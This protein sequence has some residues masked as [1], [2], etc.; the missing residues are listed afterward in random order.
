MNYDD[1]LAKAVEQ[2]DVH[3]KQW[4]WDMKNAQKLRMLGIN[5]IHEAALRFGELSH[6]PHSTEVKVLCPNP[7]HDDT[8]P[9]CSLWTDNNTFK[10]WSCGYSGGLDWYVKLMEDKQ[11]ER[12]NRRNANSNS[13]N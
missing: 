7:D 3:P 5:N 10:C 8:N 11:R 6:L 13:S 1:A 4:L 12:R 2:N 9:S